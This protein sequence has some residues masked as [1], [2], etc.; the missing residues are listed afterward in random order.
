MLTCLLHDTMSLCSDHLKFDETQ[1]VGTLSGIAEV[2]IY[3][4]SWLRETFS[5]HSS[6]VT[7]ELINI[8]RKEAM[9]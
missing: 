6:V 9:E 7:A 5:S 3:S 8:W 2:L 1:K 4:W